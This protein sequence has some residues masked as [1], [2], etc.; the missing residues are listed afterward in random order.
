MF[1]RGPINYRNK[2]SI[3]KVLDHNFSWPISSVLI[4]S[5][6][7]FKNSC[8]VFLLHCKR[9]S[10]NGVLMT[11]IDYEQQFFSLKND[12]LLLLT[13]LTTLITLHFLWKKNLHNFLRGFNGLFCFVEDRNW[14]IKRLLN[15][16]LSASSSCSRFYIFIILFFFFLFH[17]FLK[18]A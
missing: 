17:D 13:F 7:G 12:F 5:I 1:N 16:F 15:W 18:F 14:V 8:R 4:C 9:S 2:A 10:E 11:L 3:V 6:S